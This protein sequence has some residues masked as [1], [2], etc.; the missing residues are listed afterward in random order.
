MEN[1]L[2]VLLER[3][4]RK[5]MVIVGH[6]AT[7]YVLG[8]LILGK[9]LAQAILAPWKRPPGCTYKLEKSWK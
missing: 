4:D 5:R 7:Q 1:F 8:N 3:Y 6:R 2:L 9:P